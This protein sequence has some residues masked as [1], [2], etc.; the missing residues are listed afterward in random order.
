M[1][2]NLE[3]EEKVMESKPMNFTVYSKQGCPYCIKVVEVLQ[4]AELRHVVMN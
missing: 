3:P 1:I 4:L 2:G